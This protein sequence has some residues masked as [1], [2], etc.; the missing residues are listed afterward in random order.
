[1]LILWCTH[2]TYHAS[3]LS[4]S[5]EVACFVLVCGRPVP[6]FPHADGRGWVLHRLFFDATR[7]D[8]DI[9]FILRLVCT[10]VATILLCW[11]TPSRVQAVGD[12]D[13]AN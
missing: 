8:E 7:S 3:D 2:S 1:M 9:E 13:H 5:I 10:H 12:G 11:A 6:S 4:F